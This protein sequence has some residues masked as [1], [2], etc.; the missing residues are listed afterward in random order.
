MPDLK[1]AVSNVV[2]SIIG[3]N[4]ATGRRPAHFQKLGSRSVEI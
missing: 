3:T 2:I 4:D 1:G